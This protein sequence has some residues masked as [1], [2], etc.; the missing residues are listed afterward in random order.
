MYPL[1]EGEEMSSAIEELEITCRERAKKARRAEKKLIKK[2]GGTE[3][4]LGTIE[5][6]DLAR[7]IYERMEK[8]ARRARKEEQG[9]GVVYWET[10]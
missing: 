5:Q 2:L 3:K 4:I 6:I 8:K 10:E 1:F 7:T 9:P